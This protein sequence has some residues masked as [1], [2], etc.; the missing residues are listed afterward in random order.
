MPFLLALF[1]TPPSHAICKGIV[2]S[3]QRWHFDKAVRRHSVSDDELYDLYFRTLPPVHAAYIRIGSPISMVN[4]NGNLENATVVGFKEEAI[5]VV[6]PRT[7]ERSRIGR[8]GAYRPVRRGTGVIYG[9]GGDSPKPRLVSAVGDDNRVTFLDS[10]TPVAMDALGLRP[11]G[12]TSTGGKD[13][14]VATEPEEVLELIDE[15]ADLG[16]M[17]FP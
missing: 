15:V 16:D 17:I 10:D 7:G 6:S 4:E 8:D 14:S 12:G 11:R 1:I 13:L 5:E 3:L 9:D 2:E